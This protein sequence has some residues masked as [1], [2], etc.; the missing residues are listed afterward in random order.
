MEISQEL[1][2]ELRW[3]ILQSLEAGG[4]IG[5]SI[6]VLAQMLRRFAPNRST[7]LMQLYYLQEKGLL[8]IGEDKF[9]QFA[10]LTAGGIDVVEGAVPCPAGIGRPEDL[11]GTSI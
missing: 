6:E 9:T 7:L 8:E 11:D 5:C 10:K 4:S 3:R 2:A 1:R